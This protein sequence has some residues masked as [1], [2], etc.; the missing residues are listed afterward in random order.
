MSGSKSTR[1][2]AE[3]RERAVRMVAEIRAVHESEWAAMSKVAELLGVGTP[4]TVRKWCR[5][6]EVDAGRRPGMTTEESAEL[7]RL[8]RENAELKRANAILKSA[9]GFLR[10]RTRPAT[11]LIVRYVDE[12]VG[13]RDGDGLRWGVESI[14]DQL[15]QLGAK[16][17]P[18]TYYEHRV[19]KPTVREQRDEE[20]KPRIAAVHASNY[21]VY[22]ARKVWLTLNRERPEDE[23]P[24]ARCTVER[25]MG[26]LGLAGAVR[27]KVK[28]TTISDPKGAKPLDLVDR[29][30]APLAPD[31]L[32]VAD[33]TYVSTWSGWCYT[34]FVIDAYA[35]RILGWSV[36]TTMTSQ[37][38]VDAVEQAIWTRSREGKDLT[39]L[40]AHHDH[41]VQYM[42]VAYS[43]RL[44]TAGI[45]PS[46]GA[47][48]SS[49]DNALAESVIGLYKTE[50]VKPR[51]PWKGL[52]DLEIATA[53]W[54]D[55]FN[56]RRPFEYCD[57]LTP[58]EAEQAH[59][60]H[61]QTPATAG[62]SN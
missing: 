62:V 6:A 25:L 9:S 3:L 8:K 29:N 21:G 42:S 55:W 51:R 48:G 38:V 34:A 30:F 52:D 47:V 37:L 17:A 27:G 41:G 57:D 31:R 40:I 59:Y 56:H 46:T 16:I 26:D 24:I 14:C 7:K 35:R 12:H 2:P 39:G 54:A 43:E 33:F 36:A 44:D 50:L 13:V 4:E 49:Y 53:E 15:T 20:L 58:V 60:A 10:G 32:W 5:Q 61:H 11:A 45:K 22:G 28:R 1:Y 18:A 23:L 19:R